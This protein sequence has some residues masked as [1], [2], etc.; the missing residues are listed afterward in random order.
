[1][2][3]AVIFF[4]ALIILFCIYDVKKPKNFPP[5]PKWLPIIGSAIEVSQLQKSME[6]L[7]FVAGEL[8]KKYKSDVVGLKVGQEKI[9]IVYGS[10]ELKDFMSNEDLNGRPVGL[11]YELRTWNERLGILCTDEDFWV[12][13]RRFILRQLREFGFGKRGMSEYIEHEA[14]IMVNHFKKQMGDKK[15]VEV[16]MDSAF[17]IHVLNTLWTMLAGTNFGPE[18][19]EMIYLQTL[20]TALFKACHMM[21]SPFS[22]FPLIR[23]IMPEA[24]GYRFYVNAHLPIWE[25][26]DK[27]IKHHKRTIEPGNPRDFIDVYLEMIKQPEAKTFSEKQ[28]LSICLDMF[29]AG[30][31]TT[32]KTL[33]FCFQYLLLCPDVQKKAQEE[34]DRVIG[35]HRYPTLADRPNMPYMEALVLESIRHFMAR[36]FGVPHRALKDAYIGKHFIP[37]GTMLLACFHGVFFGPECNLP[38]PMG[39]HPEYFLDDKGKLTVPDYFIPFGYGKRRCLG[40]TLA[41]GNLFILIAAM[42]QNFN[43]RLPKDHPPI[44]TIS[45][46]GVTAGPKPYRSI[47][48]IRD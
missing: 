37:K 29:M 20:L 35:R 18:D 47:V 31:E 26:I 16:Q 42:L 27:E 15:E 39:F 2:W 12:E 9:V 48:E 28:L 44:D 13:Q 43:V 3:L 40:E 30:S 7:P 36:T 23:F 21:G 1:M 45:E 33:N 8:C 22:Y 11:F 34:I 4:L 17:G 10:Q 41:R 46:D 38:D 25:F 5:G 14:D 19:E 6:G 24:S 32:T